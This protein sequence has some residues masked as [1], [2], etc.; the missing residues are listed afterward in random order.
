M[1]LF[2]LFSSCE[3]DIDIELPDYESKLV[4]EGYIENGQPPVVMLTK[5]MSYFSTI[6]PEALISEILVRDAKVTV[7]SGSGESE[8]LLFGIDP[9]APLYCSYKGRNPGRSNET[10][11]LTVEWDDKIYTAT[12]SILE[13]FDIDSIWFAKGSSEDTIATI[14]LLLPDNP[15]TRDYYQFFVKIQHGNMLTDRLWA[16]TLPLVFDDATFNGIEFSYE[17]L[18]GTPSTIF[19]ATLSDEERRSYY[20]AYYMVGDT[21]HVKYALMDYDSYRFWMTA[22]SDI[23]FGQNIFMSPPPIES[24]IICNTGEAVR[25]VW[26][27]YASQTKTL[28]FTQ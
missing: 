17:I 6:D 4:I 1:L 21:V 7:T 8:T 23:T 19:A 20:R 26:C 27:G 11:T 10:Y 3:T 14:R 12:T 18:R 16:Y 13:P 24:N 5:S 9:E 15:A 2:F 28:I 22:M 25:G